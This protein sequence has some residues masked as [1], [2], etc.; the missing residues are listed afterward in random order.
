MNL[1]T[2][3]R[4]NKMPGEDVWADRYYIVDVHYRIARELG[5]GLNAIM[6]DHDLDGICHQCAGLLVPGSATHIDPSHY[7]QPPFDP[8]EPADEYALDAKLLRWFFDHGKPILGICGGLQAINVF[9]GGT[10]KKVPPCEKGHERKVPTPYKND[11]VVDYPVHDILIEKGSFVYDV[12]GTERATVNSYHYW[13]IDR[14]APGLQVAA[15]SEDGV[16]EA[17]EWKERN[18]FATQWHPELS[19]DLGDPIERKFMENFLNC[20]KQA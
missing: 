2:L 8:P 13:C 3:L 17:V 18:I 7:G 11:Q 10:L 20:C 5:V 14:L 4:Y 9:L 16:I 12:F 19:F 1:A 15:R 6:N